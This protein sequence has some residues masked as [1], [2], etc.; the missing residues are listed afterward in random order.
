MSYPIWQNLFFMWLGFEVAKDLYAWVTTKYSR[1]RFAES[2][3]RAILCVVTWALKVVLPITN[4]THAFRR[5]SREFFWVL[6]KSWNTAQGKSKQGKMK[7]S[8]SSFRWR[9]K[10]RS[11]MYT[12]MEIRWHHASISVCDTRLIITITLIA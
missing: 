6:I 7:D 11:D 12:L 10:D 3:P 5:T 4:L 8:T 2:H 1:L 9:R